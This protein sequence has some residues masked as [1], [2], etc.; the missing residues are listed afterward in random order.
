VT[1]APPYCTTA[2]LAAWLSIDDGPELAPAIE[3][4][5]RAIDQAAGR[6]F[7]SAVA[8][9]R[10]RPEDR[11]EHHRHIFG[12]WEYPWWYGGHRRH[13]THLDIDDLASADSLEV[14][15]EVFGGG[16]QALTEF[17]LLPLNAEP[18]GRPM[19]SLETHHFLHGI[20]QITGTWGWVAVPDT[21]RQATM[22]QAGRIVG[23]RE[24]PDSPPLDK[25]VDDVRLKWAPRSTELDPD[26]CA[27][28]AAYRRL[29]TAV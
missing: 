6:Q 1:W 27:M 4:A 29:W 13:R 3:A 14:L 22:I 12:P 15:H 10:F 9:R 19:T 28:I 11:G 8:T 7:G 2:D 26:V 25:Q 17:E 21:I 20:V 23:R 18:N 16:L 5:S 24:F